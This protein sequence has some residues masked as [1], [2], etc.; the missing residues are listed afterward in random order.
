MKILI[1]GANGQ[2][3]KCIK[4][5]SI[6]YPEHDFFFVGRE[7]LDIT[8]EDSISNLFSNYCFDY[9]INTAAYTRVEQAEINKKQAFLVN[10]KGVK[11]LAKQCKKSNTVLIQISTDYVFDG[12]KRTPYTEEDQP[13]PINVYGTSKLKGEMFVKEFCEKYYIIRTSW[14]Y[15]NYGH[16]FYNSIIKSVEEGRGLKI[17]TEQTGTPTNAIDLSE[18]ILK[19]ISFNSNNFGVFHISNTGKSTWYDFAKAIFDQ[20]DQANMS[21]LEK[22]NYFSTF[23]ERPVFSVLNTEKFTEVF[24]FLLPSWEKSLKKIIS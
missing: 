18:A 10:A 21:K 17:T 24:G 3:G 5:T 2:L 14:L 22:V 15:S 9:C 11:N 8:S 13:N 6:N 4:D 1:T 7:E 12:K 19:I 23:A 20:I 16:N